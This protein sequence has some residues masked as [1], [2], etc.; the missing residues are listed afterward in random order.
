MST[1]MS[2]F[3]RKETAMIHGPC[4]FHPMSALCA[5]LES[6]W[7]LPRCVLHPPAHVPRTTVTHRKSVASA[8]SQS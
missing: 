2:F 4:E 6:K 7:L 5:N 3:V 8:K 1:L